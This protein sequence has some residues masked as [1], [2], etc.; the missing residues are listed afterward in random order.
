ML[1]GESIVVGT[2]QPEPRSADCLAVF[3]AA[4]LRDPLRDNSIELLGDACCRPR[5][6]T[7]KTGIPRC[8]NSTLTTSVTR[9][10]CLARAQTDRTVSLYYHRASAQ[11]LSARR[12]KSP[13]RLCSVVGRDRAALLRI[14]GMPMQ[15]ERQKE[16]KLRDAQKRQM[17]AAGKRVP[18]D[19]CPQ[20]FFYT[21]QFERV[22]LL[23]SSPVL[24]RE[25]EQWAWM[26]GRW[27]IADVSDMT[28]SSDFLHILSKADELAA[29]LNTFA[30][31][32]RRRPGLSVSQTLRQEVTQLLLRFT[33]VRARFVAAIVDSGLDMPELR[34]LH[35]ELAIIGRIY[36]HDSA[37][38]PGFLRNV[39]EQIDEQS[40]VHS[41]RTAQEDYCSKAFLC[42]AHSR[43]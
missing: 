6:R 29:R 30:D 36:A 25:L 41:D 27:V 32:L 10:L 43:P 3:T 5:L 9:A 17:E 16:W 12:L 15:V 26:H 31:D 35:P 28:K 23:A 4:L 13:T 38:L 39:D 8:E 7:C 22:S 14:L 18:A 40:A 20:V 21:F 24:L 1:A 37:S 42:I 34:D 33:T 19:F 11:D 2:F